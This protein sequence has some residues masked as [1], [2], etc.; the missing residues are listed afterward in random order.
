MFFKE[1]KKKKKWRR[2]LTQD[3]RYYTDV[4]MSYK[5]RKIEHGN[6]V[7]KE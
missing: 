7:L 2:K 1:K 3:S 6:T 4:R 5:D